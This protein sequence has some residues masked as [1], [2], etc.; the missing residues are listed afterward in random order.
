MRERTKKHLLAEEATRAILKNEQVGRLG[1]LGADGYPYVTPLHYVYMGD[2][3][4]IHGFSK[5]EKMDNIRANPQVGFEVDRMQC[6]L[7]GEEP[8]NT[9]TGYESVII[10]GR[11][12]MVEDPAEKIAVLDAFVAKYT[13]Q[14]I[15]KP[16]PESSVK[17][18]AIVA[19]SV[20]SCTGKLYA[21]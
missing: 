9:N 5:G 3:I 18:T 13:P 19:I 12:S 7:H 16:F 11:V 8:C 1:S 6:L 4:Y 10:R 21:S 20:E 17:A 14:H 15:G 2:T